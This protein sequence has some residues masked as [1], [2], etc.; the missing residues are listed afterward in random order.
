MTLIRDNSLIAMAVALTGGALL[1]FGEK[2]LFILLSP[3][4]IAV[5]DRIFNDKGMTELWGVT[6]L[7]NVVAFAI[8]ALIVSLVV[9][10]TL[11]AILAYRDM[12]YPLIS[13]VPVALLGYWW[14]LHD[15]AGAV[16]GMPSEHIATLLARP[17]VLMAIFLFLAWRFRKETPPNNS[18]QPTGS[19]GG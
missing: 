15:S 17:I 16:E 9:A 4:T 12:F 14:F 19:A 11:R 8:S 10:M 5:G 13:V 18:L 1:H 3:Y 6:F 2:I 7:F